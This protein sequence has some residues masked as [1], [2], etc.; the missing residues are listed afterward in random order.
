MSTIRQ[1]RG[2][3]PVDCM[4]SC[5]WIATVEEGRVTGVAGDKTHPITR[6]VL[7]AKLR[8]YETRLTAPGRV[9]HPLRRVGDKGA[10]EFERISWDEAL[11]TIAARFKAI[12]AEHGP[13][14]LMPLHYLGSM[15]VVQRKALLRL[16]HA[17]GASRTHGNVC[18]EAAITFAGRGYPVGVDPETTPAA[19]LVIL[20]GQ[21]VLTTAHHQWHFIEEARRRKGAKVVAID[22]RATRTTRQADWHLR[23]RPGSD[24]VLAAA[25][26]RV[27]IE[28]GL[29]DLD[30]AHL[31]TADLDQYRTAV[32]PWTPERAAAATGLSADDIVVLA[33][34]FAK[35]QPALIRA[36]IAPQQT[37]NGENFIRQL[38]AL[39]IL[40]G[41]WRLEGGGLSILYWPPLDEAKAGR[42]DLL[43]GHPRSLD[44]AKLAEVLTD[45]ALKPPVKGLMVWSANPATTQIDS[46]RVK[47][48]LARKD[49]FTVVADHFVTDTARFADILLPATT[50]LEHVDV[51]GAWGHHYVSANLPAIAPMGEARSS[52]W[53]M[54][55][56]AERMGLDHP[57]LKESDEAI[58]AS[59]LPEGWTL[60][61]L[62]LQ[63]WRAFPLPRPAI[64]KRAKP[65]ELTG[66]PIVP[67]A[68]VPEGHLQLL[69]PK[70]HYFLNSS[71]ANMPRQ[72]Q[73]QGEPTV[74]VAAADAERL[75]LG[76]AD[77]VELRNDQGQL[78]VR[79][80]I[81][82][83]LR[84]GVAILEGKWWGAPA[85][86]AAEMN[87]L[88]S[89]R[90]SPEGQPA[91]N[92]CYVTVRPVRA[93]SERAEAERSGAG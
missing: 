85:E 86:T 30:L 9:L 44:M 19:E 8:D 67:P 12:I 16:F 32:A 60:E 33:R 74:Q 13:E 47:R 1:V 45:R 41:H 72:R 42:P 27:L 50:Q 10:G 22:P 5:A 20:W 77:R 80:R 24:A 53:M 75:G 11:D 49:L 14:A 25:M 81:D 73:S 37:A 48:G 59:V 65:L 43:E 34:L 84:P 93:A 83:G 29:A 68:A 88:T 71:F 4:D 87:H 23:P 15:G 26:G 17:L 21:N 35:A 52:G 46:N 54:R 51:Q 31:W 79:V 92:E 63:G 89:S 62:Q 28:E 76:Q 36:G 90:W 55:A 2:V 57:A 38:S 3:C 56:L 58:A 40:G 70:S 64:E 66:E 78:E 18:A 61:A 39:A 82:D 6:G 91:Y 7:C 69:T